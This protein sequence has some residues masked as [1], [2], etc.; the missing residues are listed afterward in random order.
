[1]GVKV[2]DIV[3]LTQDAVYY[4]GKEMPD[5]VKTDKWIVKSVNGDRA[6]IDKNVSGTRAICSP[7]NIAYPYCFL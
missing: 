2:G 4:G 1:M 3:T 5:W 6:I 7:V